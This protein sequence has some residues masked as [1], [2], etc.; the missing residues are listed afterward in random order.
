MV[1]VDGELIRDVMARHA[2]SVCVVTTLFD[3][4]LHGL[5]VSSFCS[6][7]LDPPLVL[8]CVARLANSCEFI[9]SSGLYAVNLLSWRQM[10]LADRFSG[11]APLVGAN[12]DEVQYRP[13]VTGAPILEG[14]LAW[15]DCRVQDTHEGGDHV[16]FV[17]HVEAA[18]LGQQDA[19][20]VHVNR[21]FQRIG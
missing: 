3:G 12:F 16:I 18:G 4:R 13:A 17:G 10:F 2:S 20:L 1:E 8:V 9:R 6:V 14:C 21:R 7:S 15:V 19:A 11:R 5:T